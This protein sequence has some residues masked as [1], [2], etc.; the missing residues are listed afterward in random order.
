MNWYK[1]KIGEQEVN[2]ASVVA[3]GVIMIGLEIYRRKYIQDKI[4]KDISIAFNEISKGQKVQE[5]T[6]TL[7][8]SILDRI[9]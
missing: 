6:K 2:W 1:I 8:D 7:L 3:S 5:E 4:K 9:G